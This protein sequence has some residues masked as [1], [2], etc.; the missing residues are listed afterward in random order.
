VKASYQWLCDLLPGLEKISPKDLGDRLTF[1]GLEVEAIESTP[2]GPIF[3]INVTP[4]RGDVL[5]HMGLAIEIGALTGLALNEAGG[6]PKLFL[7]KFAASA[8]GGETCRVTVHHLETKAC[9]RYSVSTIHGVNVGAS[10]S[11]LSARLEALG[12][13][14]INAV[15]DATNYVM[16]L[17]G[18]PVH[19]FDLEKLSGHALVVRAAEVGARFRTLDGFERELLRGDLLIADGNQAV[20]LAGII[21]GENSEVSPTTKA[22]ALEVAAFDPDAVRKTAKRLG[23]K[24]ESSYRFERFV[25]PNRVRV[26]H[27]WLQ[28]LIVTMVG[29]QASVILD[30][31]PSPAPTC[32]IDFPISEVSRLLGIVI[33]QIQVTEIL[34]RL[35]C[36]VELSHGRLCV[37][38]PSYRPDLTRPADLVEE[39][40]RLYGL[41]KIPAVLP[42]LPVHVPFESKVS[43]LESTLKDFFIDH[44][45]VET[46]HYSFGDP[47]WF[48]AVLRQGEENQWVSLKNP[49]SEELSVMRPSLL[50]HLL[51]TY[52]K[53][54]PLGRKG[55]RLFE[56]RSIFLQSGET[57]VLAG[58]MAGNPLGK[59]RFGLTHDDDFF[60]V[61]GLVD[62]LLSKADLKARL[63]VLSDWPFH[64]TQSASYHVGDV[65]LA[66]VGVLHP[67]LLLEHKV[68]D[69]VMY[70][71]IAIETFAET[72]GQ[73]KKAFR[74]VNALPP[75]Y[76]D[77]ALLV[78]VTLSHQ[79]ILEA[80]HV[81]K[82]SQL[83]RVELFDLYQGANLEEGKKSLA[84]AF[85][86][87][88][89]HGE[90]MTD[91][92]VNRLHFSLVEKLSQSLD[93][94][95][96][97]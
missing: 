82:P 65:T 87:E 58:L 38:V 1:A 42:V 36:Q 13:R 97:K 18:N 33:S 25:D 57:R 47:A 34:T 78:P 83:K 75:V 7:E 41:D 44:G 62:K 90:A 81:L 2:I 71:E 50:P 60:D 14:A 19:A 31:Y 23:I 84:Y 17:T 59:N 9:L 12:I 32:T 8:V 72:F 88:P 48:E 27:E 28:R 77:L 53:N 5:G 39:I 30:S 21:G 69:R 66:K 56:S 93:V 15:V 40:A 16:L 4:N 45:F 96:R 63:S 70:F 35:G 85:V 92:E 61:K 26:A 79:D 52:L 94:T 68:R 67:E 86:Y 11:W 29:G 73:G 64:P 91:D 24:T 95:I 76:R 51:A 74:P 54:R 10:P 6:I 80:I 46:L 20:A 55:I 43:A 3:E 89:S 22:L 49:L 37:G